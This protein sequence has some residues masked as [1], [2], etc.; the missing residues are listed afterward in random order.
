MAKASSRLGRGLG[1]L[2]AGGTAAKVED[3]SSS[4]PTLSP[5][6]TQKESIRN[7]SDIVDSDSTNDSGDENLFSIPIDSIP[8]NMM[9][10]VVVQSLRQQC[11]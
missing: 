7:S 6:S 8:F 9:V 11:N 4:N 3:V 10:V 1:S 2:I 5:I